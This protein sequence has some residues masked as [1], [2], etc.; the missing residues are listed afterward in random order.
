MSQEKSFEICK[1]H[2]FPKSV[3]QGSSCHSNQTPNR[4]KNHDHLR[5]NRL[6][7]PVIDEFR[8]DS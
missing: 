2:V 6:V 1:N 4:K 8:G 7:L 5:K 3:A